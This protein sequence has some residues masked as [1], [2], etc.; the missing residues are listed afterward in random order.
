MPKAKKG[1][2]DLL[3]KNS[4]ILIWIEI[5]LMLLVVLL[6]I[7]GLIHGAW[8]SIVLIVVGGFFAIRQRRVLRSMDEDEYEDEGEEEYEK[9][10]E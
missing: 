8:L 1:G 9:D 6:G 3:M 7:W 10:E 4:R 5:L 2:K